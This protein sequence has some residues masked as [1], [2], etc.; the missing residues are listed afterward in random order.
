MWRM[1]ATGPYRPHRND[2]CRCGSGRKFKRC[3]QPE[4]DRRLHAADI[5]F[6]ID[7][8]L[9]ERGRAA[10]VSVAVDLAE[11]VDDDGVLVAIANA[12]YDAYLD[13]VVDQRGAVRLELQDC[14]AVT[15]AST[16]AVLEGLF[17]LNDR[18]ELQEEVWRVEDLLMQ[19]GHRA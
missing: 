16:A 13:G 11:A 19:L 8:A 15:G 18:A 1:T 5:H 3:C 12:I 10:F 9:A 7:H 4:I 17:T 6:E 2:P 14:V